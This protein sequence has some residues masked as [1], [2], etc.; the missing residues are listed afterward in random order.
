MK[1]DR[2]MTERLGPALHPLLRRARRPLTAPGREA[3]RREPPK[4]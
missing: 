3:M 2:R 1:F 4:R